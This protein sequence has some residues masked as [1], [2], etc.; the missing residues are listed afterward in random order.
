MAAPPA[1]PAR[2]DLGRRSEALTT[3][4]AQNHYSGLYNKKPGTEAGLHVP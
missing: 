1:G 2:Q 4:Y 3:H